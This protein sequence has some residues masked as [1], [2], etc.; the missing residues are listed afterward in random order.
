M[1]VE[2][3]RWRN[4]N[5]VIWSEYYPRKFSSDIFLFEKC[6]C[7]KANNDARDSEMVIHVE[8]DM[9]WM[10]M[11]G[12]LRIAKGKRQ[13]I[14]TYTGNREQIGE[15]S[16]I[17]LTKAMAFTTWQHT[18][19]RATHPWIRL[20]IEA[21]FSFVHETMWTSTFCSICFHN[22]IHRISWL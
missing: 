22:K 7:V 20:I 5:D 12:W 17:W 3:E 8:M 1:R 6:M 13:T 10:M 2:K 18:R 19:V 15:M 16:R 11:G 14:Q 4:V 9:K 21:W